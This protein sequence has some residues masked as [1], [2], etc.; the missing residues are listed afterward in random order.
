MFW[1][2]RRL[3]ANSTGQTMRLPALAA[4]LVIPGLAVNAQDGT[5]S[6]ETGRTFA[7]EACAPCHGTADESSPRQIAI[8]PDFKAIANIPAT[9]ATS[10]RVFLAT[11]HPKMPNLILTPQ[12]TADVVAYILS[13]RDHP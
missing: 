8:A 4:A 10:L 13:L 11:S 3:W 7:R 9:T 1:S 6:P 5:G 12:E 2:D